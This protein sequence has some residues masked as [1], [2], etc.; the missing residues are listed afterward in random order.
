MQKKE[1]E[2]RT[3]ETVAEIS[4]APDLPD[5][6]NGEDAEIESSPSSAARPDVRTP[7]RRNRQR[8]TKEQLKEELREQKVMKKQREL[9]RQRTLNRKYLSDDFT[10]I[11]T[12]NRDLLSS[13]GYMAEEDE[14]GEEEAAAETVEGSYSPGMDLTADIA[15]VTDGQ[16]VVLEETVVVDDNVASLEFG[17]EGGG[18]GGEGGER[19]EDSD[20]RPS[21][22]SNISE[23]G[24]SMDSVILV[25]VKPAPRD[26]SRRRKKSR[27]RA[28]ERRRGDDRRRSPHRSRSKNKDRS[29]GG[30][31]R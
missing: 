13:S 3:P 20:G 19:K 22:Y 4:S 23:D 28:A 17:A 16:E 27:D 15:M 26:D 1:E 10:S 9:R 12:E 8:R 25:D 21:P 31:D 2:T 24:D 18:G 7:A 5:D 6:G 11:F 29:G 14:E 30:D